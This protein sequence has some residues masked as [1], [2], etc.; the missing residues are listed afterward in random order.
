MRLKVYY[1]QDYLAL[2]NTKASTYKMK[3]EYSTWI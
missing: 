3:Y 2:A 1:E